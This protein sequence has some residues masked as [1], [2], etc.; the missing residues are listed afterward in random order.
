MLAP[1]FPITRAPAVARTTSRQGGTSWQML[2]SSPAGS[3]SVM[4]EF[5]SQTASSWDGQ[6]KVKD[7]K[8]AITCGKNQDQTVV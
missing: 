7:T 8:D 2:R 4:A 3:G 5:L 6:S 1:C